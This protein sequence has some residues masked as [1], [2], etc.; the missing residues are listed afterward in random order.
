MGGWTRRRCR[1]SCRR[2]GRAGAFPFG[3]PLSVTTPFSKRPLPF[4]RPLLP[5]PFFKLPAPFPPPPKQKVRNF[6]R[7]GRTKWKHLLA[8]DTSV[9]RKED[10]WWEGGGLLVVWGG[11]LGAWGSGAAAK[12]TA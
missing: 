4:A 10:E 3:I 8:E 5:A 1:R 9:V 12:K 11:V 2:A 6:G 7:T